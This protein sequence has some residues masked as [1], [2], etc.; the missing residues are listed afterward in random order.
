MGANCCSCGQPGENGLDFR[1]EEGGAQPLKPTALMNSDDVSALRASA[2]NAP[3]PKTVDASSGNCAPSRVPLEAEGRSE[4]YEDGSSY[5]GQFGI[6]TGQR[7]GYGVWTSD[8][9]K[10]SGQWS[11]DERHGDGCQEWTDG[12]WYAGGFR[13]G[14]F[15]GRGRMEWRVAGGAIVYDG[16]YVEDRKHGWGRYTWPDGRVYDG[17]WRKGQR[18]GQ[19]FYTN[20]AGRVR[21]GYWKDDVL[22]HWDLDRVDVEM[23]RQPRQDVVRAVFTFLL[24]LNCSSE[25]RDSKDQRLG[26]AALRRFAELCGFQEGDDA[27]VTVYSEWCERYNWPEEAGA[28]VGDFMRLVND[29]DFFAYCTDEELRFAHADLQ[30][31]TGSVKIK[32]SGGGACGGGTLASS[33]RDASSK[34]AAPPTSW[35]SSRC[36]TSAN[37]PFRDRVAVDV[38]EDSKDSKIRLKIALQ[39]F[40]MLDD[41]CRGWVDMRRLALLSDACPPALRPKSPSVE[42]RAACERNGWD[43]D[44]GINAEQFAALVNGRDSPMYYTFVDLRHAF[45]IACVGLPGETKHVD[46]QPSVDDD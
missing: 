41:G 35:P 46:V 38:C 5:T 32:E 8:R 3:V 34:E 37:P 23:T 11:E 30:A 19:A 28:S 26:S 39:L 31:L 1:P 40:S 12:R 15:H 33:G 21:I 4:S 42:W 14:C 10:Y 24:S 9:E 43:A 45:G 13:M 6:D 17:E 36:P 44:R 29:R 7:Q 18:C 27:W 25:Q 2:S 16:Q 20:K 22:Q